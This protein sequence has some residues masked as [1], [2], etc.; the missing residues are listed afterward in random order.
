MVIAILLLH[1]CFQFCCHLNLLSILPLA[2][3]RFLL[4]N[5]I[6]F[7]TGSCFLIIHSCLVTQTSTKS[8]N[9]GHLK[10]KLTLVTLKYSK[11]LPKAW[12]IGRILF[13]VQPK[14]DRCIYGL[15]LPNDISIIW[16]SVLAFLWYQFIAYNCKCHIDM[17]F[18]LSLYGYSSSHFRF[19]HIFKVNIYVFHLHL[20]LINSTAYFKYT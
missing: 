1:K 4:W 15:L 16:T 19:I 9:I 13:S 18:L 11:W 10:T 8:C 14:L 6:L 12:K 20:P 2:F 7:S 5:R 3:W 17:V